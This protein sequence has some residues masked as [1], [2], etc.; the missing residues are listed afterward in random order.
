M[1][2]SPRD[3]L[4]NSFLKRLCSKQN[5]FE[6]LFL[7]SNLLNNLQEK[8]IDSKEPLNNNRNELLIKFYSF[9]EDNNQLLT[10][11]QKINIEKQCI[12][13]EN[14]K[15]KTVNTALFEENKR[16]KISI[17]KLLKKIIIYEENQISNS[18]NVCCYCDKIINNNDDEYNKEK[19]KHYNNILIINSNN[20]NNNYYRTLSPIKR[21]YNINFDKILQNTKSKDNPENGENIT[22]MNTKE[23]DYNCYYTN[24]QRVNSAR[25]IRS[26]EKNITK[27]F[28]NISNNNNLKQEKKY[29]KSSSN[30]FSIQEKPDKEDIY[31]FEK[32]DNRLNMKDTQTSVLMKEIMNIVG[33]KSFNSDKQDNNLEKADKNHNDIKNKTT[34]IINNNGNLS[35]N[36]TSKNSKNNTINNN[37]I[38]G[39]NKNTLISL[40]NQT[41][42]NENFYTLNT[43]NNIKTLYFDNSN[44]YYKDKRLLKLNNTD[45]L[46]ILEEESESISQIFCNSANKNAKNNFNFTKNLRKQI[47]TETI[48][49]SDQEI[50]NKLQLKEFNI[51]SPL[52][53][54]SKNKKKKDF[55][56]NNNNS[57]TNNNIGGNNINYNNEGNKCSINNANNSKTNNGNKQ[58][59]INSNNNLINIFRY[60]SS[61]LE[62]YNDKE[63]KLRIKETCNE[64]KEK[65]SVDYYKINNTN[66]N[67]ELNQVKQADHVNKADKVE[68]INNKKINNIVKYVSDKQYKIDTND[69][70]DKKTNNVNKIESSKLHNDISNHEKEEHATINQVT[71]VRNNAN[72]HEKNDRNNITLNST[73]QEILQ[74]I[75]SI[76]FD[77]KPLNTF[78]KSYKEEGT[79]EENE[80]QRLE[81][82]NFTKLDYTL[83]NDITKPQNHE[84]YSQ[85]TSIKKDTYSTQRDEEVSSNNGNRAYININTM[86]N[87]VSEY[88]NNVS[89]SNY[90]K[91]SLSNKS[92]RSWNNRKTNLNNSTNNNNDTNNNNI[93]NTNNQLTKDF[94]SIVNDNNNHNSNLLNHNN[95]N[96]SNQN[97]NNKNINKSSNNTKSKKHNISNNNSKNNNANNKQKYNSNLSSRA[98][99]PNK[100]TFKVVQNK[101]T[102]NSEVNNS[103]KKLKLNNYLDDYNNKNLMSPQLNN[104]YSL[105]AKMNI[106]N[107]NSNI[108]KAKINNLNNN[109]VSNNSIPHNMTNNSIS[110]LSKLINKNSFTKS[111][112]KNFNNN[113]NTNIS[114]ISNHTNS[115]FYNTK[116]NIYSSKITNNN[117]SNNCINSNNNLLK[118]MNS[119]S[120]SKLNILPTNTNNLISK[121]SSSFVG[122]FNY[123]YYNA[124]KSNNN[125]DNNDINILDNES[126]FK[127]N[128]PSK[129]SSNNNIKTNS[130]LNNISNR[131]NKLNNTEN[132]NNLKSNIISNNVNVGE[133]DN[134]LF[135]NSNIKNKKSNHNLFNK[136]INTTNKY[137]NNINKLIYNN[138]PNNTNTSNK[139]QDSS[140]SKLVTIKKISK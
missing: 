4:N 21:S 7:Q 90:K 79:I 30:F 54:Y 102:I 115:N 108:N 103:E 140:G 75:N 68:N 137:A 99:T 138:N 31:G 74:D 72:I 123:N 32:K 131:V 69:N 35:Y 114:N 122:K 51:K 8:P 25:L 66:S 49:T 105:L 22:N 100:K 124:P 36:N 11:F 110:N 82:K 91:R 28:L 86:R 129:N 111:L 26:S 55:N 58:K 101:S 5:E 117:N 3:T 18:N 135:N 106:I 42:K 80:K 127:T 1:S 76:E 48:L 71:N 19:P 88:T 130:N 41:N 116:N 63:N 15:Y 81:I 128:K 40:K 6:R 134:S 34:N 73:Q 14:I 60:E 37:S 94:K 104:K 50:D 121:F 77:N 87:K 24:H 23:I 92:R 61:E 43:I 109:A 118:N 38:N 125:N 85:S 119:N 65:S 10:H 132:L 112:T 139:V 9:I 95:L 113:T 62:S 133:I 16:I 52:V 93:N 29:S 57:K 84:V 126:M 83:N 27:N 107:N 98:N 78:F 33:I 53:S 39:S 45:S 13:E 12:E 70:C 47:L 2:E 20:S 96:K 89:N 56:N 120:N 67:N 17:R 59:S 44:R 136:N 46:S 97:N 64:E